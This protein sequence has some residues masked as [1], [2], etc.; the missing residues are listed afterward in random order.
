MKS[1]RVV[2][3]DQDGRVRREKITRILKCDRDNGKIGIELSVDGDKYRTIESEYKEAKEMEVSKCAPSKKL[4]D[5]SCMTLDLVVA[6]TKAY[7]T[8]LV[9]EK[10]PEKAVRL[11]D[12]DTYGTVCRIPDKDNY[13][14][15][16]LHELRDRLNSAC[17]DEMCW[18]K[19]EFTKY[20]E[21]AMVEEADHNTFRPEGPGGRFDWLATTNIDDVMGQYH[22]VYDDFH[23][24]GTFPSDFDS[25]YVIENHP[26]TGI[27]A[28]YLHSLIRQGKRRFGCVF[29]LDEHYKDGSHWVGLYASAQ[30]GQVRFFDSYGDKP[31]PRFFA[32]MERFAKVFQ[33]I[34]VAASIDYNRYR[35][36][37]EDSECGVYSINFIIRMLDGHDFEHLTRDAVHDREINLCRTVYFS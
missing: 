37:F 6:L 14:K 4:K 35:H 26:T 23:Y 25:I 13:R 17:E 21:P 8:F 31:D 19:Q 5:G 15:Y 27:S 11:G 9:K 34:G 1:Q 22:A 24:L 16:L 10:K 33:E 7:N 32:L 29:N 36:Q 20:L 18:L 28:D 30:N 12:C 2:E 3:K